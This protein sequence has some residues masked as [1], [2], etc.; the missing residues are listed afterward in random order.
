M[1]GA[2]SYAFG[3]AFSSCLKTTCL[4]AQRGSRHIWAKKIPLPAIFGTHVRNTSDTERTS[5]YLNVFI[6][7]ATSSHIDTNVSFCLL[8]RTKANTEIAL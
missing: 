6:R 2:N 4:F 7:S 1:F 5:G 3:G 8:A